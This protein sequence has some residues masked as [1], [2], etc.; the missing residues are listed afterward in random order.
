MKKL[1]I[2]LSVLLLSFFL[3]ATDTK[4]K[5]EVSSVVIYFEG[6]FVTRSAET[7]LQSGSSE[8]ILAD[9]S[10]H[11]DPRSIQVS[12]SEFVKIL[13]VTHRISI[14][15]K[16]KSTEANMLS[17]QKK[18]IQYDKLALE[19][20]IEVLDVE[21][22]L[23]LSNSDFSSSESGVNLDELKLASEFFRLRMDEIEMKKLD[24]KR[25]INKYEDEI[26]EITISIS[27]LNNFKPEPT[28][29]V[30]VKLNADQAGKCKLQI[31]YFVSSATWTPSYNI[32]VDDLSKELKLEVNAQVQQRTGEDWDHVNLTLS[33]SNP[34]MDQTKPEFIAWY[35]DRVNMQVIS[36]NKA[37]GE[38]TLSGKIVDAATNEAIPFANVVFERR[39]NMY[40]GGTSDY[41]GNY[42]FKSV[43]YGF[44]DLKVSYVG[45]Q[46]LIY[47]NIQFNS[48]QNYFHIRMSPS[49]CELESFV[50]SSYE[51]AKMPNR[52]V[53]GI[54]ATAGGV[55]SF[56]DD[57]RNIRGARSDA[58]DVVI[59]HENYIPLQMNNTPLFVNYEIE[60]PYS[61]PSNGKNYDVHVKDIL[62]EAE[63]EHYCFPK[64]DPDAFLIARITEWDKMNLIPG[65]S[66]VFYE[67]TYMGSTFL[68]PK[69]TEDT[70]EI[71]I[72]RD[73]N[74]I[75]TREKINEEKG[76]QII[77]SKVK[78][79]QGYKFLIRNSKNTKINISI[80][81]QYPL[82]INNKIEVESIE[83]SE[84]ELN[85]E[86]GMLKWRLSVD[87]Y[88][89]QELKFKYSIKYQKYSVVFME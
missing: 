55:F 65:V 39:G 8:I 82:H 29:E 31:K 51:V 13:S 21:K 25:K 48:N 72:G 78:E 57:E 16:D 89:T 81:D 69:V 76:K 77:G 80:I 40:A 30:V 41:N 32:R 27:E 64:A 23:L 15:E 74:V 63:Y 11:L 53:N 42:S 26:E 75:V 1:S 66:N 86:N 84:A 44:Y 37:L 14:N 62:V 68:N 88:K 49:A 10:T 87:P 50:I 70:L 24:L 36:Y 6:A 59:Q 28:S 38:N 61:I 3:S 19:K 43:S 12:S 45:Y 79:I 33:T 34:N 85:E 2:L 7:V 22:K 5:S 60:I 83:L 9:L 71:S 52:N 17:D 47:E 73:R 4:I 67:G 18:T 56:D 46:P 20:K 35:L 54:A 58:N